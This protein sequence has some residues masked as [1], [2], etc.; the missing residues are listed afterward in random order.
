M[1]KSV[2]N[3]LNIRTIRPS[4]E[5]VVYIE[6]YNSAGTAIGK[7][8]IVGINRIKS[9]FLYKVGEGI[10]LYTRRLLQTI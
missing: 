9:L 6:S 4:N 3:T 8:A 10:V 1:I 5:D 2:F 7:Y